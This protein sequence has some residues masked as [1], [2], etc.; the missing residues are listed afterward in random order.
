MSRSGCEIRTPTTVNLTGSAVVGFL[1]LPLVA[2]TR[3]AVR[4]VPE[5]V[6]FVGVATLG[7]RRGLFERIARERLDEVT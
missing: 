4:C 3:T 7:L 1:S 6:A 2:A 5:S